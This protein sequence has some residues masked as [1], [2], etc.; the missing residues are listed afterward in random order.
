MWQSELLRIIASLL[1]IGLNGA[2]LIGKCRSKLVA[3]F[4]SSGKKKRKLRV[5]PS[6]LPEA[7]R[8]TPQAGTRL[9]FEI[10]GVEFAFRYC[11]AGEFTMGSP[12]SEAGRRDVEERR[13]VTLTRG[14]WLLETPVTQGEYR[15]VTG[16]NPS[17]FRSGDDFPVE[18]VSWADCQDYLE[19]L[20]ALEIAPENFAFR[21]PTE[22][23]WEYA[24]RAG[25][26][27]PYNVDRPLDWLGWYRGNSEKKTRKVRGK[28]A[29]AWGLYDM[30]GNVWEWTADWYAS[31]Y[32]DGDAVDPAG[33]NTGSSRVLRGG[34][35]GTSAVRCRS[36]CRNDNY[37][38][39][40]RAGYGFRFA[41]TLRPNG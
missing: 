4:F 25:T 30:H 37:P 26:T 8:E 6:P 38:D 24:C 15:A 1:S 29:N 9:T 10:E 34:Y 7:W 40:R 35:W 12:A 2:Q 22:A 21:L 16:K 18:T 17:F 32:P 23:E 41:L 19:A 36:A 27:G 39:A 33:P 5:E 20:N 14:F 13:K 28:N 31:T 11:P 3:K